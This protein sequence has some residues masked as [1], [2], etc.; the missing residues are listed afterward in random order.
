[1][2]ATGKIVGMIGMLAFRDPAEPEI[3]FGL[4]I[5]LGLLYGIAGVF[6]VVKPAPFLTIMPHWV[7]QPEAVILITGLCE[8]AG[9]VAI[10]FIPRLH[11]AA[12]LALALYAV[13]VYPANINHAMLDHFGGPHALGLWYHVP[14]LLLQPVLVWAALYAGALIKWP[15]S[16]YLR[17]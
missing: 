2:A 9:A 14:R 16:S 10:L 8:I 7:P 11:A 12:G 5:F 13:C 3:R 4:R 6:H 15:F 1:M 17:F